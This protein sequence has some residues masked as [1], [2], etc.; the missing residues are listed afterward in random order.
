M[1]H[2]T[3]EQF[4]MPS[5][6]TRIR[7]ITAV[8]AAAVVAA[9]GT[10]TNNASAAEIPATADSSQ[11][12]AGVEAIRPLAGVPDILKPPAEEN[13]KLLGAERVLTGTQTYT[14]AAN[15]SF[16]GTAST[17]EATLV[18]TFGFVHHFAG[19]TWQAQPPFDRSSSKVT[20]A[21]V[22]G[23]DKPGTIPWLLLKVNSSE[24]T[25]PLA[26][27]KY[28]QRLLTSGGAAPTTACTAGEKVSVRYGAVYVFLG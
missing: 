23:V 16:V 28:I 15:G 17:P 21:R 20:A 24:G 12:G 9:L 18:G 4:F 26:K 27:T 13:V 5:K 25:G 7:S 1:R 19:P 6:R 8:G 22:Q 10:V 2:Q 11:A 14:C 3:E